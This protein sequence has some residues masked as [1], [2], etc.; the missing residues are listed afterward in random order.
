MEKIV[1]KW[2]LILTSLHYNNINRKIFIIQFLIKFRRSSQNQSRILHMSLSGMQNKISACKTKYPVCKTK[3]P[4]LRG[5]RRACKT[6]YLT[7]KWKY[8]A[9]KTNIQRAKQNILTKS[10]KF[11]KL[12]FI[13]KK[14]FHE[15]ILLA[16][17]L[18][19]YFIMECNKSNVKIIWFC[20]N[21]KVLYWELYNK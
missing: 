10:L 8:P 15:L 11:N 5:L 7:C 9:C 19:M 3:Y 14:H 13:K 1:H 2:R 17:S 21:Y 16:F 20:E 18:P 6:K 4:K 12:S